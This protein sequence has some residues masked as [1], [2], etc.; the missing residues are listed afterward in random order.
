MQLSGRIGLCRLQPSGRIFP[1]GEKKELNLIFSPGDIHFSGKT[2]KMSQHSGFLI[3]PGGGKN[4][5]PPVASPP[6]T[7]VNE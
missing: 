2:D 5:I 7:A 1:A 4:Y 6:T 3:P